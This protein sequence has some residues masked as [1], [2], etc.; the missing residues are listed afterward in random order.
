MADDKDKYKPVAP[1]AKEILDA[2]KAKGLFAPKAGDIP[3]PM[4]LGARGPNITPPGGGPDV[5]P[6]KMFGTQSSLNFTKDD[7]LKLLKEEGAVVDRIRVT[8]EGTTY[9]QYSSPGNRPLNN[10]D[11]GW[12]TIRIPAPNDVHAGTPRPHEKTTLIDT[13]GQENRRSGVSEVALQN[14]AN[15]SYNNLDAIRRA[16]QWRLGN[17]LVPE[18]SQPYVLAPQKPT[19][20]DPK[21]IPVDPNQGDF[22]LKMLAEQAGTQR[23]QNIVGGNSNNLFS[24]NQ[25]GQ[26]FNLDTPK[27]ILSTGKY[28]DMPQPANREPPMLP[29]VNPSQQGQFD[30]NYMELLKLL[31]QSKKEPE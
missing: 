10:K 14:A 1:S 20:N 8:P 24:S 6:G 29:G 17:K 16:V 7:V 26:R 31:A 3:K 9:I 27:S 18:G 21:K 23:P 2:L 19:I 25:M 28:P 4:I 11:A 22:L 30:K 13:A 12:P 15:E 5:A